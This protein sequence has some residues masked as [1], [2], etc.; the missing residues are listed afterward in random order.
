MPDGSHRVSGSPRSVIR[1]EIDRTPLSV[2]VDYLSITVP[3][4]NHADIINEVQALLGCKSEQRPTGMFGYLSSFDLDGYGIVAFGGEHQRGTVLVSINGTGMRR[5]ANYCD[6]RAW[7][8]PLGAR[9]TRIDIAAD[10]HDGGV[11]DVARALQA[12]RDGAFKVEGAGRSSKASLHDDLG[13][14]RGC[15]LNVGSREGGK[16]CRVYEKGKQLGDVTSAWTRA[17]VQFMAKDRV[18]PWDA[19]TEPVRYLAGAYPFFAFLSLVAERIRTVKRATAI[20]IERVREW[21][22]NAAG[23]SLNALVSHHGGD[24]GEV[25]AGVRRRGLPKRLAVWVL[26]TGELCDV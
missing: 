7:F 1:G 9:I 22:R 5:I 16:L 12:W 18:I 3:G 21:V 14:G 6:V 23:K 26:S 19:L 15:T 4:G 13:S 11:L 17:E 24:L 25:F 20:T 2:C 8:E 10:D